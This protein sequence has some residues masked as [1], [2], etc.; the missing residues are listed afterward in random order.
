MIWAY[1]MAPFWPWSYPA[2][3]ALLFLIVL[4]RGEIKN[5]LQFC[6]VLGIVALW[7]LSLVIEFTSAWLQRRWERQRARAQHDRETGQATP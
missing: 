6:Q 3:A 2:V 1:R 7:P 5:Y 4:I